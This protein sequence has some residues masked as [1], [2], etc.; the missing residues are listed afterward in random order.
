[1]NFL[2]YEVV[3]MK[4]MI[5]MFDCTCERNHPLIEEM[6]EEINEVKMC[7]DQGKV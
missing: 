1:M 7:S 4:R 6:K 5:K 2:G 3:R